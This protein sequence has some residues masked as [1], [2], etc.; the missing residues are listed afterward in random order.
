MSDTFK[1]N[2]LPPLPGAGNI[3]VM[4]SWPVSSKGAALPRIG[5]GNAG[6]IIAGRWFRQVSPGLTTHARRGRF[7]PLFLTATPALDW[8]GESGNTNIVAPSSVSVLPEEMIPF[9]SQAQEDNIV[10]MRTPGVFFYA[11]ANPVMGE[12]FSDMLS[13]KRVRSACY[14]CVLDL[15][16]FTGEPT[17]AEMAALELTV[18]DENCQPLPVLPPTKMGFRF[19]GDSPDHIHGIAV[20]PHDCWIS[21]RTICC[22]R[23][24]VTDRVKASSQYPWLVYVQNG[25][26]VIAKDNGVRAIKISDVPDGA[27]ARIAGSG[28]SPR[29][30]LNIIVSPE[31]GLMVS[32]EDSGLLVVPWELDRVIDAWSGT[33]HTLI[34]PSPKFLVPAA[35]V[36]YTKKPG[37][38][39]FVLS[40]DEWVENVFSRDEEVVMRASHKEARQNRAGQVRAWRKLYGSLPTEL[41]RK[42]DEGAMK[43]FSIIKRERMVPVLECEIMSY[44]FNKKTAYEILVIAVTGAILHPVTGG[45]YAAPDALANARY[46]SRV[47]LALI[48][49]AGPVSEFL[50]R[51][52]L[53]D[54]FRDAY[55]IAAATAAP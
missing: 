26:Q 30:T 37:H 47:A 44:L 24:V 22:R 6:P 17:A 49:D 33:S 41:V 4:E 31:H 12:V 9:P 46:D 42:G 40:E 19:A 48:N 27:L 2:P 29:Q 1:L 10:G 51:L 16:F 18:L 52:I 3:F 43:S 38:R 11:A 53:D 55:L 54:K 32:L 45:L 25:T 28:A 5:W 35:N 7:L 23:F 8:F 34:A 13:D 15:V 20:V 50:G 21:D 36:A 39:A 14:D